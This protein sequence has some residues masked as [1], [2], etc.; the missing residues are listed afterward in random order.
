MEFTLWD[1]VYVRI[2]IHERDKSFWLERNISPSYV[3]PY[4]IVEN[5]GPVANRLDIFVKE[6]QWIHYV[7][8]VFSLKKSF[9]K[10]QLVVVDPNHI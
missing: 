5:V 1:W 8:Y 4:E 2:L 10:Q 9:E 7:F 6:L 3:G